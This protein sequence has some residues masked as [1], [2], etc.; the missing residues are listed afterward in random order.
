[1]YDAKSAKPPETFLEDAYPHHG[2]VYSQC[3]DEYLT[4]QLALQ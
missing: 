2:Y 3:F 4:P 1:M